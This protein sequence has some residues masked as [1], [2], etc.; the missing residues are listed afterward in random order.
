MRKYGR[1]DCNQ[2]EV[3]R[4]L[5]KIGASVQDLSPVGNGC[6][7]LL[8]GWRGRDF[9]MEVKDGDKPPS[10]RSLTPAQVAWHESWR[11]SPVLTVF[12]PEHAIAMLE[13]QFVR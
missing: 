8:V 9:L 4:A 5:R 10:E 6:P 2:A 3:V 7:D 12:G 1:T 11:G 13:A